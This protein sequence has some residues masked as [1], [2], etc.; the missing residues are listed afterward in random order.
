MT[1]VSMRLYSFYRSEVPN[2]EQ[3][4]NFVQ[5]VDKNVN[6]CTLAL[7]I[8]WLSMKKIKGKKIC[9]KARSIAKCLSPRRVEGEEY[10]GRTKNFGAK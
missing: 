8:M 7:P 10:K 2:D 1:D 5:C 4:L 3:S 9:L 6:K